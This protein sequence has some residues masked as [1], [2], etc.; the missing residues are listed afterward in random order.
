M[1]AMKLSVISLLALCCLV[2]ISSYFAVIYPIGDFF[3]SV[4]NIFI[5]VF[6]IPLIHSLIKWLGWKKGM[7]ILLLLGGISLAVEIFAIVTGVPYGNFAYSSTLGFR[8]FTV[9]ISVPLA[10]LP[11]LFGAFTVSNHLQKLPTRLY[12]TLVSALLNT[13][14]DFVIDPAAVN[15]VFWF[16]PDGG[17]YYGV[18]VI[19]FGGWLFTGFLYSQILYSLVQTDISSLEVP[20]DV[21]YSL[22]LI[23]SFWIGYTLWNN[24]FIP[25]LVGFVILSVMIFLIIQCARD[26]TS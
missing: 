23:L 26:S 15:A 14:I 8:L 1:M 25:V 24:L 12:H 22:L 4:S 17:L 3:T 9:P 7:S 10:Y 20:I 11:I 2:F 18:P 6:A 13:A 16:W 19:N 21:S 5:L